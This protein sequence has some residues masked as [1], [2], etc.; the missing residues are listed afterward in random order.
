MAIDTDYALAGADGIASVAPY[1]APG[2]TGLSALGAP[3]VDLGALATSGLTETLSE[4][5]TSF[6]RWGSITTFKTVV[7]DQQKSFDVSFLESNANVL[8]V[9]YKVP[10]PTPSGAGTNEVQLVT[11]TGAP[12]GGTF[13]L[14]FGNVSTP[15]L[16]YNATAAAVQTALQ[17]L[18]G[19]GAGNATVAGSAGGPYTV[20]FVGAL[21]Q[22]NIAALTAVGSF[23]GGT[24][25]GITVSTTTPGA[26]GSLLQFNDDTTG[27]QDIRAW[28]FDILEGTNHIRFYCPNAEVTARKNPVYVN[29]AITEYGVTITAYV[30]PATGIS[31]ARTYLL[32]AVSGL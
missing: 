24:T 29:S 15:A 23:T 18:P 2:P 11:I 19:I 28:T 16:A 7:T 9:F 14:T 6:K 31:V 5:R 3:W 21:A 8:G 13:S 25:P 20:T 17:A 1:A 10:T 12:T 22:Q 30:D 27:Q 26:A 4:T 32:D